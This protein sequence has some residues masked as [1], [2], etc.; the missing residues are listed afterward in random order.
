MSESFQRCVGLVK[1]YYK[2]TKKKLKQQGVIIFFADKQYRQ[3][4]LSRE[5]PS[6][7]G[8]DGPPAWTRPVSQERASPGSRATCPSVPRG[9]QPRV[10]PSPLF[11]SSRDTARDAGKGL[12]QTLAEQLDAGSLAQP[13]PWLLPRIGCEL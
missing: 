6:Q 2:Q 5:H 3:S 1:S 9:Q 8:G 7:A 10:S 12:R 11:L 13:S 4:T